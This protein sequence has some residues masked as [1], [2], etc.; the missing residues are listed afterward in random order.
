MA[1]LLSVLIEVLVYI[2]SNSEL[3]L[4]NEQKDMYKNWALIERGDLCL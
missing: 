2:W 4:S 1:G 3:I